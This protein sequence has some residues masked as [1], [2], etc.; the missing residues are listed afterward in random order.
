MTI[1][2]LHI[3]GTLL[4]NMTYVPRPGWESARPR[5]FAHP[6]R[7]YEVVLLD[8]QG[9]PRVAVHPE[10]RVRGCGEAHEPRRFRLL[11][12]LPLHPDGASYEIRHHGIRVYG[13]DVAARPPKLHTCDFHQRDEG[14][15]LIWEAEHG[16]V[17]IVKVVAE[18]ERGGR[19][20]LQRNI[21]EPEVDIDLTSSRLSGTGR[22]L[23]VVTDGVRSSEREISRFSL[24]E[25]SA[26]ALIVSPQP[27]DAIREGQP[28]SLIGAFLDGTGCPI[29]SESA[30]WLVDGQT[31][32][33]DSLVAAVDGLREGHHRL[34]L[35]VRGHGHE[36]RADLALEVAPPTAEYREWLAEF[37]AS[38][39]DIHAPEA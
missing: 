3:R 17:V 30:E 2:Y 21:C 8:A 35:L 19:V 23:V 26:E 27:D 32:A 25:R 14:G 28:L 13:A 38:V 4:E 18:P 15:H 5:R 29:R 33:S 36:A 6:N 10:V 12:C 34:S 31:V 1:T 7:A 9:Q 22:L 39:P 20:T 11:A 16:A 37:R 24:P